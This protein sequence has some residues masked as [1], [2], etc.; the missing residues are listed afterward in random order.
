L[1]LLLL[2][3]LARVFLQLLFK[4]PEIFLRDTAGPTI[5]T[6]GKFNVF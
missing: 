1:D 5:G 3:L 6:T 4:P 2:E